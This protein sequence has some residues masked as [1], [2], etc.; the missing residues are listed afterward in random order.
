MMSK[1]T[2]D[3][4]SRDVRKDVMAAAKVAQ[5]YERKLFVDT[6]KSLFDDLQKNYG[7]ELYHPDLDK[8]TQ[9]ITSV[10]EKNAKTMGGMDYIN[11]IKGL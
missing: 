2:W 7:V 8:W 5:A 6:E 4:L 11:K 1:K 3:K 10:Y 9:R